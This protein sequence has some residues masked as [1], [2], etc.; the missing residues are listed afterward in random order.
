M[1]ILWYKILSLWQF[2]Y[3]IQRYIA[4][5]V[6]TR[7]ATLQQEYDKLYEEYQVAYKNNRLLFI[8]WVVSLILLLIMV[9]ILFINMRS[10]SKNRY[11]DDDYDDDDYN[12][13]EEDDDSYFSHKDNKLDKDLEDDA[14]DE[15]VNKERKYVIKKIKT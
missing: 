11:S 8:G 9:V 1:Y 12:D 3:T 2:Q 7:S 10:G 15:Y 14:E 13:E 5:Q 4:D 6:E